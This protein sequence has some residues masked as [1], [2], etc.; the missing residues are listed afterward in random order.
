MLSVEHEALK[1]SKLSRT[2][3]RGERT[4][5]VRFHHLDNDL[6]P[7]NELEKTVQE[8]E[9]FRLMGMLGMC[10]L[11]LIREFDLCKFTHGY[12]RVNA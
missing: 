7:K 9:T 11:C 10:E 4:P 12:T 6:A 2:A 3:A 5:F 1:R 8:Q